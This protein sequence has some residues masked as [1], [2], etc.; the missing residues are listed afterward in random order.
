MDIVD[1]GI[2]FYQILFGFGI[3]AG[4]GV[5][6]KTG[7]PFGAIILIVFILAYFFADWL[8]Y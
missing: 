7:G 6:Y 3:L 2:T 4:V 8:S 1:V 5:A